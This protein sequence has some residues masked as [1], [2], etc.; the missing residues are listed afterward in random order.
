MTLQ[1]ID[2]I[3]NNKGN[4]NR[5]AI[6]QGL[7]QFLSGMLGGMGGCTTIGQSFMNIH[8]G[9]FT[10]LS[11]STAA[12]FMLFIIL[13][14]YPLINLIPVASLAGV[15]FVVTYF[16]IEWESGWV[17]LGSAL[18]LSLRRKWGIYTKV[19]RSDVVIM[20]IVVAVT[21]ILDLAIAVGVGIVVACLVFSWDAGTRVSVSRELDGDCAVYT[22]KGPIFFGSIKPLMELFPNPKDDPPNA[23]VILEA[24]EIYDWSGMVAIKGLHDRF[25]NN[26]TN[27]RF[28][29]LSVASSRLMNK[30]KKLWEGMT[31]LTQSDLDEPINDPQNERTHADNEYHAHL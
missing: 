14:A 30:S 31:Y 7:G 19:K 6:G 28:Q 1:L 4:S 29:Q 16:T 24:A 18:P 2:E 17:V 13:V 12:F 22:V 25:E 26:G 9:G 21:L 27:V 11:S 10:R 15:M 5:E 20:L 3:L 23:V 8:S